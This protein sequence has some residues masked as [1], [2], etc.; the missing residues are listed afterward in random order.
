MPRFEDA[1]ITIYRGDETIVVQGASELR[2]RGPHRTPSGRRVIED[3]ASCDPREFWSHVE[4]PRSI[5][6]HLNVRDGAVEVRRLARP[7][8]FAPVELL[9]LWSA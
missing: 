5:P 7:R 8:M 2:E 3:E 1:A 4:T 9:P 6:C